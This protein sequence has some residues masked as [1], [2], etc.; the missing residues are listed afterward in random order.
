MLDIVLC[1]LHAVLTVVE[2][3]LLLFA[4]CDILFR[5][6]DHGLPKSTQLIRLAL[7]HSLLGRNYIL[8]IFVSSS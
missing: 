7:N 5:L 8:I 1:I 4:L 2:A 3:I 6:E